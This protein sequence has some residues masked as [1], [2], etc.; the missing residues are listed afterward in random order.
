MNPPYSRMREV[1]G[2]IERDGA[3]AILLVPHWP[4]EGWLQ[5]IAPYV[6]KR[7]CYPAGTQVF[8]GTGPVRWPV[9]ALLV[10]G[11]RKVWKFTLEKPNTVRSAG[12]KRRWSKKYTGVPVC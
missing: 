2:K 1:V 10:N 8:E 11:R 6:Q 4:S 7:Y 9:W 12:A 3:R 5:H